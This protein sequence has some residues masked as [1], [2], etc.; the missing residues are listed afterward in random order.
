MNLK[1]QLFYKFENNFLHTKVT[2]SL[3]KFV[4]YLYQ[5]ISLLIYTTD[6]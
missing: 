4:L 5:G 2:L 3:F 6:I 1:I